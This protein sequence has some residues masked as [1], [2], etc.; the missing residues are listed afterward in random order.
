MSRHEFDTIQNRTKKLSSLRKNCFQ[1]L[2]INIIK[3]LD[4]N[5]AI[6]FGIAF[7]KEIPVK[8]VEWIKTGYSIKCGVNRILND[9]ILIDSDKYAKLFYKSKYYSSADSIV[10]QIKQFENTSREDRKFK[11]VQILKLYDLKIKK[12][13]Y[14]ISEEYINTPQTVD[15]TLG[16]ILL[17][18]KIKEKNGIHTH[19][20]V[21][22][23]NKQLEQLEQLEQLDPNMSWISCVS[24]TQ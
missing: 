4:D 23:Y 22:D 10:T 15:C 12:W 17:M 5:D 11:L 1:N 20:N 24:H 8:E 3:Y 21:H 19:R 16:K 13:N 18:K 2:W 14:H 6:N 7:P 9:Y